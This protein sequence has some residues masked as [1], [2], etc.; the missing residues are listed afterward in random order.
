MIDVGGGV[1]VG[2]DGSKDAHAALEEAVR[3]ARALKTHVTV[4]RAWQVTTMGRPANA[5]FGYVPP[6]DEYAAEA[7]KNLERDVEP[8]REEHPDVPIETAV[9]N[10]DPAGQLVLASGTATMAVVGR[11]GSGGV[12]RL[13]LG[14]VSGRLASHARCPVLVVN[15]QAAATAAEVDEEQRLEAALASELHLDR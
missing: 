4:V 11:R 7:R 9:V 13:L 10:G 1:L 8:V 14:S 6:L 2:H 5:E 12:S 3:I 15:P